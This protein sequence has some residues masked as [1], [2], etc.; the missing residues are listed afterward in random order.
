M[1]AYTAGRATAEAF[2]LAEGPVWDARRGRL[3]W[4]DILGGAVLEGELHGD[5]IDVVGR[6]TFDGMVGAVVPAADGSLV[7]AGERELVVVRQDGR[8]ERGPALVGPGVVSRTNDA[9]VG[10]DGRLLVGT[11]TLDDTVGAERLLQVTGDDVRVID[12]DLGLSNG[13]GWSPDGAVLYSVDTAARTVWARDYDAETGATGARSRHLLVDGFPDGMCVDSSGALW[14]ALWGAG[15]VRRFGVDGRPLDVVSTPLAPH[16]SSVAF[17]GP[18]LDLLVV[19][20]AQQHLTPQQLREFPASG[21]LFIARVDA[22][23]LP[24]RPY[25]FT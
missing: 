17:A 1:T 23:G 22:T 25:A 11:M 13:I 19:T 4:V 24:E 2:E 5:G 6:H 9:A 18:D 16:T 14:I 7:V 21:A 3:L 15:E 10:P 8:R 20:T 12:D